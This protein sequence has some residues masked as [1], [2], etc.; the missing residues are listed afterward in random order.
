MSTPRP[1][2]TSSASAG[3]RGLSIRL[4]LTLW[5]IGVVIFI[6]FGLGVV[7]RFALQATL[8]TAIDH[9]LE[10]S[11][12]GIRDFLRER[13]RLPTPPPDAPKPPRDGP[14]VR[15]QILDIQGNRF[16]TTGEVTVPYDP[17]GFQGAL[18]TGQP[19]FATVNWK[20]Q[21]FR[22]LSYPLRQ[23]NGV[24][25]WVAQSPRPLTETQQ[26][27]DRLTRLLFL[28]AGPG[29]LL[30]GLGGAFLTNRALRPVRSI[31]Q[32]AARIEAED[33]SRR[34]DVAGQDELSEL[35]TTFN[36]MLARLEESF[37][38]RQA[39]YARV[40]K[41]L[42]QQQRFT[43]DAS[44]E[45][46]S[47][48]TVIEGTVSL[49]LASAE[50]TPA[51]YRKGMETIHTATG[52]MKGIVQDLLLLAQSDSGHLVMDFRPLSAYDVMI[53][54]RDSVEARPS[55]EPCAPIIV[56]EPDPPI[57]IR[58]D[59]A[60]LVRLLVN[61]LENAQRHTPSDGQITL[62]ATTDTD[63]VRITVT[64]TGAGIP[65]RDL[66]HIFDRFYRVDSAR[67]RTHGGTG[68]GLAIGKGIAEAHGGTLT[69]TSEEGR[70]TQVQ[71][72]LPRPPETVSVVLR[73][74]VP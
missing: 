42:E 29:V 71:L 27:V 24:V 4:R 36:S 9:E 33:L 58:A 55:S 37:R 67:A 30:G 51:Q 38:Q 48:L 59:S 13:G 21:P 22:V 40:E 23:K 44:H 17:N 16:P 50:R 74:R 64:D 73:T 12:R 19:V 31:T 11:V 7:L 25:E 26:E 68:L 66:P 69:I 14:E 56:Q 20:G 10:H 61:L 43:A 5:N 46:K 28:L 57:F 8:Q 34:L 52:R 47:P 53:L 72:R 15:P 6:L 49:N 63:T 70:R 41:A 18:E 35:A 39:A 32:A 45:L 1:D 54:A 60:H 62:S 65:A 2:G 3:D